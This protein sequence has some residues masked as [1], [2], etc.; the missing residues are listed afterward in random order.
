MKE[1]YMTPHSEVA[2]FSAKDILTESE[3]E[4]ESTT[5][6]SGGIGDHNN[7]AGTI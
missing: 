2:L 4:I 3:T 7:D 1:K 6:Q 5:T